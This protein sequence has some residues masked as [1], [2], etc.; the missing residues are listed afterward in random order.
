[1]P[2]KY[3]LKCVIALICAFILNACENSK[4]P[5]LVT[6][7]TP[8]ASFGPSGG[9]ERISL[10]H[11]LVNSVYHIYSKNLES[12]YLIP[13]VRSQL[14]NLPSKGTHE[15]FKPNRTERTELIA[16]K[17]QGDVILKGDSVQITSYRDVDSDVRVYFAQKD[18]ELLDIMTYGSRV[19]G[20]LPTHESTYQGA[21]LLTIKNDNR[22]YEGEFKLSINFDD[23]KGYFKDL[24]FDRGNFAIA[25]L[26]DGRFLVLT[27]EFDINL[28]SGTFSSETLTLQLCSAR[29]CQGL[30][31]DGQILEN[32]VMDTTD[33]SIHGSLLSED[34][35]GI[36]AIYHDNE[37]S[38]K[39]IGA[40]IGVRGDVIRSS[41]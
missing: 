7:V 35:L 40:L 27:G 14:N 3:A 16:E 30:G 22:I 19:S 10:S 12:K 26:N 31:T 25:P 39:Y 36:A 29:I 18:T 2:T 11:P 13:D 4:Q 20:T 8:L 21:N 33:A 34:A 6:T 23:G 38:P 28:S 5:Q 37:S 32:L 17:Y 9:I 41:N 15:L 1:M 24:G